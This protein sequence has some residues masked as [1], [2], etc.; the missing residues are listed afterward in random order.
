MVGYAPSSLASRLDGALAL[1]RPGSGFGPTT[2][3][4]PTLRVDDYGPARRRVTDRTM[5]VTSWGRSFTV[6]RSM[7]DVCAVLRRASSR[8]AAAGT[9]MV[10]P[11]LFREHVMHVTLLPADRVHPADPSFARETVARAIK[12]FREHVRAAAIDG[13]SVRTR[14][15]HAR[16]TPRHDS[17]ASAILRAASGDDSLN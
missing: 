2:R 8:I 13:A 10:T 1:A 17:T 5:I 11:D 16:V 15:K 9:L 14:I 4:V 3:P 7:P 12:E 6:A